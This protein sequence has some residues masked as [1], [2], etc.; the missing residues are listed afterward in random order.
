MTTTREVRVGLL[1]APSS[2]KSSLARKLQELYQTVTLGE[3]ATEYLEQVGLDSWGGSLEDQ[4]AITQTQV[5]RERDFAE[6]SGGR[7]LVS[8]SPSLLGA[9]YSGIHPLA[10]SSGLELDSFYAELGGV[11][12]WGRDYYS[13]FY[14]L[15]IVDERYHRTEIRPPLLRAKQIEQI[16]LFY[17]RVQGI[18]FRIL[19]PSGLGSYA[20]A[21]AGD[22]GLV[23]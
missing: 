11:A 3:A 21:I 7:V 1:G 13:H 14:F 16:L 22:V 12:A 5:G 17:L 9:V 4:M 18:P 19:E 2:G 6:E 8:E 15:P 23:V 10:P 20:E